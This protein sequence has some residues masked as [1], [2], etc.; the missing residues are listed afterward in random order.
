MVY[1]RGRG[2]VGRQRD[3]CRKKVLCQSLPPSFPPF[4]PSTS[5]SS[6]PSIVASRDGFGRGRERERERERVG[7]ERKSNLCTPHAVVRFML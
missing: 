1:G 6:P 5:D 7:W 3:K 4:V 2:R